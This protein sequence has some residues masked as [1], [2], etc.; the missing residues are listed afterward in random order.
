MSKATYEIINDVVSG[1]LAL[2]IS[3]V[4]IPANLVTCLVFWRQGLRDRMNLCLFCLAAVDL[5]YLMPVLSVGPFL[6]LASSPHAQEYTLKILSVGFFIDLWDKSLGE[7]LTFKSLVYGLG[8]VYG[9]RATSDIISM[10]LAVDRCLCV[11]L[12]LR[13][14]HLIRTRTMAAMMAA[15][16]IF[17]QLSYVVLPLRFNVAK[18]YVNATGKIE[19]TLVQTNIGLKYGNIFDIIYGGFLSISLPIVNFT[20]VAA[21]TALTV[22][23]L[24]VATRWRAKTSSANSETQDRQAGATKMLVLVSC[25]YIVTMTPFVAT[26][27]TRIIVRDFS[28]YGR[29]YMQYMAI[30]AISDSFSLLNNAVN[31]FVYLAQSSRFRRDLLVILRPCQKETSSDQRSAKLF[32]EVQSTKTSL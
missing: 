30:S 29:Y 2:A 6:H 14:T 19:W 21:A 26:I 4:G 18:N 16:F 3:V 20:T 1:C 17:L 13:V 15:S 27:F 32:T 22:G 25:L 11:L 5:L 7:E 10:I 8:F 31:F 23:K 9:L 24:R 28:P 12:P